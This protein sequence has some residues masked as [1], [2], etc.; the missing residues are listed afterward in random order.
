MNIKIQIYNM[1]AKKYLPAKLTKN[2]RTKQAVRGARAHCFAF[3]I[4]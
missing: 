3:F 1:L 4:D 2:D